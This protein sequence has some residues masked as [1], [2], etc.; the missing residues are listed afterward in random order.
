MEKT[1]SGNKNPSHLQDLCE[2]PF[3]SDQLKRG[4]EFNIGLN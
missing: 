2:I 4:V 1:C 3:S